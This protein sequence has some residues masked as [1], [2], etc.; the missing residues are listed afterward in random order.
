MWERP[1]GEGIEQ[2]PRRGMVKLF[3]M[4]AQ[5]Q[6]PS[7]PT[8]P[9]PKATLPPMPGRPRTIHQALEPLVDMENRMPVG[10]FP[11]SLPRYTLTYL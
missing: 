1:G 6:A 4:G 2:S 10:C 3:G 11:M 9:P 8:K 7:P 5:A